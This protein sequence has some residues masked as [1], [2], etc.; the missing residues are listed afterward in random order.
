MGRP[1]ARRSAASCPA[2]CRRPTEL[3]RPTP[4]AAELRTLPS[5]SWSTFSL[6][7]THQSESRVVQ[8]AVRRG[9]TPGAGSIVRAKVLAAHPRS[10]TDHTFSAS[11]RPGRRHSRTVRV[12][13]F[14]VPV[15]APFP[16]VAGHVDQVE[17]VRLKATHRRAASESVF[18]GVLLRK[19]A[20]PPV[21]GRPAARPQVES[22]D[23]WRLVYS[24]S[25]RILPLRF[26]RQTLAGP[27]RVRLRVVP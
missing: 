9:M 10:A 17:A 7:V 20:L 11:R 1:M 27:A 6:D 3:R 23:E 8:T 22:P 15:G 16:N 19:G 25:C 18:A 2:C 26:R 12:I 5:R 24:A 14:V 13:A 21:G 4:I